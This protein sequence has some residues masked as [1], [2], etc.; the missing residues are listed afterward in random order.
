MRFLFSDARAAFDSL[1]PQA[2]AGTDVEEVESSGRT[3]MFALT[4]SDRWF[5]PDENMEQKSN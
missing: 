3:E 4:G 5:A 1:D 2:V